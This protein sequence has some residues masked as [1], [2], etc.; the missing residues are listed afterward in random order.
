MCGIFGGA[1]NSPNNINGDKIKILGLFNESRGKQSCGILVDNIVSHGLT[2]EK[3]FTDFSKN[4]SFTPKE[5]PIVIGHTRQSSSGAINHFNCHPF[6]FD[7]KDDSKMIAVHNGTLYNHKELA[8]K[9]E[10][11]MT[12][13]YINEYNFKTSRTKIDSEILLEILYKTRNFKV[14]SDYIGRAALVWTDLY[15][16]NTLYMW[17]GAS[18]ADKNIKHQ[19]VLEERPMNVYIQNEN[20]FY[21]SSLP[22][23]LEIIAE[24][25][26]SNI[27][28]IEYNTVYII[29]H[30]DFMNAE[31]HVVSRKDAC[32][33]EEFTN[34][35]HSAVNA[36]QNKNSKYNFNNSYYP[37]AWDDCPTHNDCNYDFLPQK[38]VGIHIFDDYAS[39]MNTHK[40]YSKKLRHYYKNQLITGIYAFVQD[41]G[42]VYLGVDENAAM[43]MYKTRI[44]MYF[45]SGL[46]YKEKPIPTSSIVFKD[47]DPELHYFIEGAEIKTKLDY[48]LFHKSMDGVN[49]DIELF[50]WITTYPVCDISK[51]TLP[52]EQGIYHDGKLYS[53]DIVNTYFDKIYTIK[54]GNLISTHSHPKNKIIVPELSN[55]ELLTIFENKIIEHEKNIVL[56]E[57]EEDLDL[58]E[59][60]HILDFHLSSMPLQITHCSNKLKKLSTNIYAVEAVEIL[61]EFSQSLNTLIDV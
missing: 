30:G 61:K 49:K 14:L 4:K 29:K 12:Q 54:E 5:R 20:T 51:R 15:D 37:D 10:I 25:K 58:K 26:N 38:E 11:D 21:F 42:Y 32:H 41:F 8:Q 3:L 28:Q 7:S 59:V 46:F 45:D 34:Y 35:N 50:S 13:E 56:N 33:T 19:K 31:K 24:E 17:S 55:D 2:T 52:A 43:S 23:S 60:E 27:F 16:P 44:G 40:V 6:T 36:Y 1:S 53:G 47:S 9:Y 22:E 48:N 57:V 18:T 39:N